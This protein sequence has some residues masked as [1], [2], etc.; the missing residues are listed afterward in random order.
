LSSLKESANIVRNLG[1]L[2]FRILKIFVS[3]LKHH[4]IINNQEIVSY[5]NLHKDRIDYGLKNLLKLKLISKSEKGFKLITAGLDVYALK[6]LVDSDIISRIGNPLGIGKESDVIEAVSELDQERAVKFFRIGRISFTDTKRKRSIEK[7]RNIHNWL[8]INIEAAK[9]E[10]D[11]LVKLKETKMKIS[12]P[13]FRSMHSI[14]MYRINGVRLVDYKHLPNPKEILNKTFEQIKIAYKANIINGD[15]SEYNIILDKNN[16]IWII[17]WP[18]AVTLD[19]PNAEFLIKRD[20]QNVIR[21]FKRKYDLQID[22]N[23]Y[24]KY[25]LQK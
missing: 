9:R 19:H 25:I 14:V 3:S 12:T 13:Y 17:D 18:Q 15:L 21:F 6:I 24:L 4:E 7:K 20:I 10:Y 16:D 8:L 11:F 22:E 23:Y 1:N 2:E 5:S